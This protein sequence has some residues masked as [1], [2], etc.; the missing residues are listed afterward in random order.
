M[1]FPAFIA[2]VTCCAIGTFLNGIGL[3]FLFKCKNSEIDLTQR[4]IIINLCFIDFC[5]SLN[6][7]V[8]GML[9][10]FDVLLSYYYY[11]ALN[12]CRSI[13][14]TGYYFATFWLIVDRY[15]HIKLN[16][17]YVIYWSKKKTIIA[18]IILWMFMALIGSLFAVYQV[19]Y[20]MLVY[21]IFDSIILLFSTYVYAYALILFKKQRANVRSNQHDRGMLK[22]LVVPVIILAAF[23]VLVAIPDT[24]YAVATFH[25]IFTYGENL[26]WY[27]W[28]V[29]PLSFWT[30]A[31][32]YI[33]LSPKVRLALKN[34]LKCVLGN[35][36]VTSKG[37]E[38]CYIQS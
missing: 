3:I 1:V 19:N 23:A 11:F 26:S 5:L 34:K 32:I 17:R 13:L 22:G 20:I 8:Y 9:L 12:V 16:I 27:T 30:D 28:I 24:I 37:S 15:L 35:R 38:L 18:T 21:A 33:F 7:A 6:F 10:T 14:N 4:Y 36:S 29:Y 31:L 2:F 25:D